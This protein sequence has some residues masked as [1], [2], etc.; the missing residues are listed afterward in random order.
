[1][2]GHLFYFV[3]GIRTDLENVDGWHY[4]A[5]RWIDTRTEHDADTFPY[6]ALAT[7]RFLEQ[8]GRAEK[9]GRILY[10]YNPERLTLACHSNGCALAC[11]V[12]RMFPSLCVDD[13]HL[14]APAEDPDFER[15]G[16]N[17]AAARWHANRNRGVGRITLYCSKNDGALEAA[18]WTSWLRIFGLG[19][20]ELGRVGPVNRSAITASE[21]FTRQVWRNDFG[22]S[23]WFADRYFETLMEG[24]VE[25][26]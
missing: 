13:L 2:K 6:H 23:T 21:L 11:M 8:K 20:G 18:G 26:S 12:L 9:L 15:N 1:M 17:A 25:T 4:R 22:H 5:K 16:L 14:I 24:L 10:G 19:Y 3:P 7:T